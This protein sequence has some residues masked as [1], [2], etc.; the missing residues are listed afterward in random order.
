MSRA[1]VLFIFVIVLDKNGLFSVSS[2]L[3]RVVF[4]DIQFIMHLESYRID[5]LVRRSCKHLASRFTNSL[6]FLLDN[7][8]LRA[9]VTRLKKAIEW[10]G[11]PV[12]PRCPLITGFPELQMGDATSQ[13]RTPNIWIAWSSS[14]DNSLSWE[15]A[16]FGES[17][18]TKRF[19]RREF[20]IAVAILTRILKD[21]L[22]CGQAAVWLDYMR[23]R[24][25]RS[26]HAFHIHRIQDF[27]S[28]WKS[29]SPTCFSSF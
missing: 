13:I 11:K 23:L 14:E 9:P 18:R 24:R 20:C 16:A 12:S 27:F 5:C 21:G 29:S 8:T 17:N 22:S 28:S 1:D 3:Y 6:F 7:A 2:N 10:V 26:P 15:A 19:R 25:P 4:S